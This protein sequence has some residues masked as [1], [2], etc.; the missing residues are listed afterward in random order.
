MPPVSVGSWEGLGIEGGVWLGPRRS[1][2]VGRTWASARPL[3]P[4][5]LLAVLARTSGKCGSKA[6]SSELLGSAA[7]LRPGVLTVFV[8]LVGVADLLAALVVARVAVLL[9]VLADVAARVADGVRVGVG[10]L[11]GVAVR[12]GVRVKVGV[13]V[14]VADLV[15]V[16]VLLGV[17]VRVGVGVLVIVG[18]LLGVGVRVGVPVDVG[19][20]VSGAAISNSAS[21]TLWAMTFPAG[22]ESSERRIWIVVLPAEPRA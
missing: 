15:A 11:L 5:S 3:G 18:V 16:G 22:S 21:C 9:G 14:G 19:V 10:V 13:R 8:F 20:G 6:L 1:A 4:L 12:V 17:A 2:G 7:K